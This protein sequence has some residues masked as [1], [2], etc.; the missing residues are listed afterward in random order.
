[1]TVEKYTL[2]PPLNPSPTEVISIFQGIVKQMSNGVNATEILRGMIKPQHNEDV[3]Q[4][5]IK[6]ASLPSVVASEAQSM[7]STSRSAT[8][9]TNAGSSSGGSIN[10]TN[11][12]NKDKCPLLMELLYKSFQARLAKENRLKALQ[13]ISEQQHQHHH[14][15]EKSSSS[16]KPN[17]HSSAISALVA[18]AATAA[19]VPTSHAAAAAAAHQVLLPVN[20]NQTLATSAHTTATNNMEATVNPFPMS[21]PELMAAAAAAAAL[22]QQQ[23]A[24]HAAVAAHPPPPQPPPPPPPPQQPQPSLAAAAASYPLFSY[25]MNPMWASTAAAQYFQHPATQSLMIPNIMQLGPTLTSQMAATAGVKRAAAPVL[26]PTTGAL[27][28]RMKLA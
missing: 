15:H 12:N 3:I 24:H 18:A 2:Q 14:A 7:N 21:N 8:I 19:T 5:A 20:A 17:H 26:Y 28:K 10:S 22:N 9:T 11:Q 13:Q 16:L 27:E 23:Q 25:Y 1:M 4:S 6:M